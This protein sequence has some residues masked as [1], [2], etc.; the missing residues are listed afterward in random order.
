MYTLRNLLKLHVLHF[1]LFFH[2]LSMIVL[3][4]GKMVNGEGFV[5]SRSG[6]KISEF[7]LYSTRLIVPLHIIN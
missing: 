2:P 5:F 6:I 7:I 1:S 4:L 3:R